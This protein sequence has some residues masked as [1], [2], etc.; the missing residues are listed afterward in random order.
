MSE[1][2]PD[3]EKPMNRGHWS[4]EEKT[5]FIQAIQLHGKNWKKIVECVGSRTNN[6]IRSHAQK[7][8][9]KLKRKYKSTASQTCD[10]NDPYPHFLEPLSYNAYIN[11]LQEFQKGSPFCPTAKPIIIRD[12]VKIDEFEADKM[13][14]LNS[15]NNI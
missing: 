11:F 4:K 10:A 9:L 13:N 15:I 6:Q 8:F 1:N 7:Y 3:F 5:R 14:S 12:N 2:K